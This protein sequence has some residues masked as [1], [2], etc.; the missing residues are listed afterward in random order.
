MNVKGTDIPYWEEGNK[1]LFPWFR[2]GWWKRNGRKKYL[3]EQA[4]NKSDY[5]DE[6]GYLELVKL[7][8]DLESDY[9]RGI[10]V[11]SKKEELYDRIS[12]LKT[13]LKHCPR[14]QNEEPQRDLWIYVFK[15]VDTNHTIEYL[16]ELFTLKRKGKGNKDAQA[17]VQDLANIACYVDGSRINARFN[18][19]TIPVVEYNEAIKIVN[20]MD[21]EKEELM[22]ELNQ[23]KEAYIGLSKIVISKNIELE[24]FKNNNVFKKLS[25]LKESDTITDYNTDNNVNKGMPDNNH[26]IHISIE[27]YLKAASVG[28]DTAHNRALDMVIKFI[29][30]VDVVGE[31]RDS[32]DLKYKMLYKI[33]SLKKQF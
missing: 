9:E 20:E 17:V 1:N 12:R 30:Q 33:D 13:Y 25:F 5:F 2:K 16:E 27:Q 24:K 14:F 7:L 22:K 6:I 8:H 4:K 15:L 19:L 3:R 11:P 31:I 18:G 26:I 29:E 10:F 21:F 23:Y 28:E 32:I